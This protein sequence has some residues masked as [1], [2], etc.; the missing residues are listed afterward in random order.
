MFNLFLNFSHL[1]I[2]HKKI[3][4]GTSLVVQWLKLHASNARDVGSISGRGTKIPHAAQR[5]Q[6]IKKKKIIVNTISQ[7][8]NRSITNQYPTLIYIFLLFPI[9]SLPDKDNHCLELVF[10]ISLLYMWECFVL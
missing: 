10:I 8:K 5:G 4:V 1:F 9:L 3:I 6:K 7:C 2:S